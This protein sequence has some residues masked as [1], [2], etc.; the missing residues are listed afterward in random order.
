MAK[1]DIKR[2]GLEFTAD[3]VQDFKRSLSEV[4]N[5]LAISKNEF[6]RT[7]LAYDENTKAADKLADKQKYLSEQ[8][9]LHKDR[10]KALTRELEDYSASEGANENQIKKKTLAIE[11]AK[12]ELTKYEVDLKSVSKEVE[13]GTANFDELAKK[14]DDV[15][16]KMKSTGES[17]TRNVTVPIMAVATGAVVAFKTI[18]EAYDN[19]IVKTGATGAELDGLTKVFDSIYGNFPF[20]TQAVS[21]AVGEVST[22][23][24]YANE[25]LEDA[26][27]A[28]LQ[29]AEI[30][31]VDVNTA[32]ASVS[33][34]LEASDEPLTKY[35]DL[36][37]IATVA[38]QKTGLSVDELFSSYEKYG[39][40]LRTVGFDMDD[41]VALL[42]QIEKSGMNVDNVFAAL[43]TANK[44]W[45]SSGKDANK[46]F[47]KTIAS[48]KNAKTETD[49]LKIA[50]ETFGSKAAV[51]F[52]ESIRTGRFEIESMT[53]ALSGYSGSTATTFESTLDPIDNSTVAMNNLTL[54]GA[55]LG[56]E[57][58]SALG[59][60][61]ESLSQ[62]LKD[63]AT[64]FKGLDDSTKRTILIILAI[65]AAIGPV[66]VILGMLASSISSLIGLWGI[67]SG[68][69][70]GTAGAAFVGM[71]PIIGGVVVA[72]VAL[73]AIGKLVVDNWEWISTKAGEIWTTVTTFFSNM[74]TG[75]GTMFTNFLN[76][77]VNIFNKLWE[78]IKN[79]FF[80][81]LKG[82]IPG[83]INDY[84]LK[85]FL[86]IDLF[87]IGIDIINGLWGGISSMVGSLFEGIKGIAG[88]LIDSAKQA[89]DINSPSKEFEK[90]GTFT[91]E[92]FA[93]GLQNSIGKLN[94]QVYAMADSSIAAFTQ[95]E[96]VHNHTGV[97]RVEGIDNQGQ[98]NSVVEILM[99]RLRREVRK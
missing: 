29:F 46:E 55:E 41:S 98:M 74:F 3:G 63:V 54:A 40:Q 12:T 13:K 45:A 4:N 70:A 87:Q 96:V 69:M 79:V 61:F 1:N 49:A 14:V 26:S 16:Q 86:G 23:F 64:W 9:T 25:E 99:D 35:N 53:D 94:N 84:I 58:Q 47:S 33:R 56:K 10:I 28:F 73:I 37:D 97:I 72:I 57:I 19:I 32:I 2:V 51:E 34:S 21:D 77:G 62:I 48:I 90:I 39:A 65:V 95:G 88:G 78:G 31:K 6:K 7:T 27:L 68:V 38:S 5:Q 17:M 92:G 89:L 50:T 44:N 67:I 59:P 80:S 20:E 8:V 60:I 30:N 83:L 91:G 93:I 36:L 18:D 81:F 85:P 66:L 15:G 75:L 22:R 24:G 42:A 52:T 76:A 71:L 11:R 82:G 43:K